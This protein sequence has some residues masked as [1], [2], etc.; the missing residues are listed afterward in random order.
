MPTGGTGQWGNMLYIAAWSIN[1]AFSSEKISG[2]SNVCAQNSI[3]DHSHC[4]TFNASNSNSI[5]G[6]SNTVQPPSLVLNYMI[7]Y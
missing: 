5:Y 3:A 7:K 1:G 6:K 4:L 2:N